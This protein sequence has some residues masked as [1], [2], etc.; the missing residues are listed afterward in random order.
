MSVFAD[1]GVDERGFAGVRTPNDGEFGDVGQ[2]FGVFVIL[3]GKFGYHL[4][5]QVARA[6]AV[7]G[8][9]AVGVAKSEGIEFGH[10]V[11][12]FVGIHLVGYQN[13]RFAAATKDGC[14]VVVEVGDAVHRV[15]HEEN[16]I[17]LF[18]GQFN[19]FVDFA[20][21]D[22][23]AIDYPSSGVYYG[24]FNAVPVDFAVLSVARGPGC[25]VGDGRACLGKAVEERRLAYI[26]TSDDG[27]EFS[28]NGV[29]VWSWVMLDYLGA[30]IRYIRIG[31]VCFRGCANWVLL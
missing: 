12:P 10:V 16:D 11:L 13:H 6:V 7:D 20:L 22:V 5:K 9:D 26:R 18:D 3:L 24:E 15:N 31:A 28:H 29:L 19:L 21:E 1:K 27:Y 14:D 23:F 2:G 25:G 17:G 4:V 30:V 8:A